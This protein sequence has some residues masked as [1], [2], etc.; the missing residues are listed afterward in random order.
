VNTADP[1]VIPCNPAPWMSAREEA[2]RSP[3]EA[4]I[5]PALVFVGGLHRSGT[6][7]V[8]RCLASHPAVSGFSGT[9]V[10]ED[11]GQHLQTVY[12]QDFRLGGAGR[13]GFRSGA[14]LTERSVLVSAE[15][16]ARLL[17][18]WGPHWQPGA[19]V[20]VEKSPPNVVRTRFLQ[21]L[22]PN[23][24]FV[25]VVRHPVVVAGAT[26]K[27][28]RRLLSYELLVRHW[29]ACHTILARDAPLVRNLQ[30]VRYE[31]LVADPD[32]ALAPVFAALSLTPPLL[33]APIK[34]GLNDDYFDHWRTSRNPL[35]RWDRRWT[36]T[37]WEA[38]VNRFGYSLV[39]L[40]RAGD[41]GL[42][43]PP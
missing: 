13:F 3:S 29:V 36:I 15:N 26:R 23:A 33:P 43:P 39:D 4:A 12:P 5:P 1:G 19:A 40:A 10:P 24:V 22:F 9:G 31:H 8:H 35:H 25:I 41:A 21:A 37:R 16:R 14:R 7:L 28:R 20:G 42:P 38:D 17:A 34:P 6:S 30:V 11:E 18:E 32:T 27:G 2:H